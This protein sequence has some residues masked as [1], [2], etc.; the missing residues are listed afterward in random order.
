MYMTAFQCNVT[1]ASKYTIGKPVPPV[2]CDGKPPCYLYPNWGNSTTVCPKVLNPLYWAN[3][4]GNNINNP[5]K[6]LYH[7]AL[8][9]SLFAYVGINSEC[10]MC[11]NIQYIL[12]FPRW[13]TKPN[14]HQQTSASCRNSRRYP[15]FNKFNYFTKFTPSLAKL[16][17]Q[18]GGP[19]RR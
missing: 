17:N 16:S 15:L 8:F 2:R 11:A 14:I 3:N 18:I 12:W 9:V 5:S 4:E 7:F 13:S 6:S 1:N 19:R 10:T